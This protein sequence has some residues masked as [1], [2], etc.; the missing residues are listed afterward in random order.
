MNIGIITTW[1]ERGASYVSKAYADLLEANNRVYIYARDGEYAKKDKMWSQENVTWGWELFSTNIHFAHFKKWILNNDID[2]LFFNEQ[3]D[4]KIIL[5]TKKVFPNIVIGSY[6]DYYTQ[7]MIPKFKFYDF[8]ICNTKRHYSVFSDITKCFYV[9]WGTD[10]E[11]FTPN[12][13]ENHEKIVFFHSVG[14]SPRKGTNK[15]INAFINGKLYEKS[16][17]ILHTQIGIGQVT[18]YSIE[19]LKQYGIEV[20]HKTVGAPGLYYLGDVYVYPTTLEGLGLT[21]YEALASGLPVIITDCP[22]M[23]EVITNEVGKLVEV[24]KYYTREDAYYWPLA[25]VREDSLRN[26][27]EFYIEHQCE[28]RDFQ[29]KAREYAVENW[30]W[31]E[32]QSK[33]DEIFKTA[34]RLDEG[35]DI[36]VELGKMKRENINLILKNVFSIIPDRIERVILRYIKTRK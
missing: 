21:I 24:E 22:P 2:V 10:V 11:V 26:A 19:E 25:D 15:L 4:F 17:M 13:R 29:K 6:I 18:K 14:M 8:L 23:N 20:I 31:M 1:Y 9:P 28:I 16:K 36:D 35:Y 33:V 7:E 5:K 12:K 30:N 27:M 34:N 3:R 32:R